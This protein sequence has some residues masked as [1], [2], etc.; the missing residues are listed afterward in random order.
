MPAL[1]QGELS[2]ALQTLNA[3]GLDY[4]RQYLNGLKKGK[5][6]TDLRDTS[7]YLFALTDTYKFFD[8]SIATVDKCI[9]NAQVQL[10]INFGLSYSDKACA[11]YW[12]YE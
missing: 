3:V 9:T 5:K 6:C 12:I 11:D 1:T 8:I 7:R 4:N 10:I 2:N